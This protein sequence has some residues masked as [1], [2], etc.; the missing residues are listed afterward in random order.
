MYSYRKVKESP[1]PAFDIEE[2]YT[3]HQAIKKLITKGL[4]QSVHDI[5][6]GGLFVALA[7]SA[8]PRELGFQ[9]ATD[10]NFRT[11]AY[12]FGEAQ[13]RV[14]VSVKA[15]Q[16]G[17]FQKFLGGGLKIAHT[18]LGTVT[19]QDFV[20]NSK[21]VLATAEAKDLYDNSLGKIME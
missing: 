3:L 10:D 7:E 9:I 8:M 15:A 6:D 19:A 18:L 1:A 16:Q 4:V 20:V 2:E 12:L 21:E 17:E 11:D 14:L 5:S 13:G